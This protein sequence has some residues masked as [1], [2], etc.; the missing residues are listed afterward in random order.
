MELDDGFHGSLG[1]LRTAFRTRPR[2]PGPP[3]ASPDASGQGPRCGRAHLHHGRRA[4]PALRRLPAV[5]HRHPGGPGAEPAR[6]RVRRACSRRRRPSTTTDHRP[7]VPGEPETVP[8]IPPVAEGEPDGPHPDPEDRRRQDRGRG[9]GPPRPQEGPGPLPRDAPARAGGQRRHRRAPHHLRR[10][11][12]PDRRAA[13]RATRSRSR[14]SRASSA[15]WSKE[16][17][18]V[19][20]DRRSRCSRTRATTGSRS[21]PATRSTAPA[22]GSSWWPSWPRTRRRSPARRATRTCAGA[23]RHRRHRR[24]GRPGPPGHPAR[25]PVR[26]DLAAG[27]AA[28]GGCGASGRAYLLGLPFFLVALFFFFEEFSR[29]LPSN[30]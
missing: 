9:R 14:R 10:A 19:S 21:P 6:G 29:L 17:Q 11:V 5:G 2:R 22:S 18:I 12:Q 16:Q 25:R 15:T 27:L 28:S 7:R 8:T 1:S 13:S 3:V 30:F 26:G 24:R 23:G 4:D 20:P